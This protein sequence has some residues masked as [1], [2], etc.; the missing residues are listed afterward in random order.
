MKTAILLSLV[1]SSLL[2]S[3]ASAVDP[4]KECVSPPY[5]GYC[6]AYAERYYYDA[7]TNTCKNF[8]YGG[9]DGN[10][11]NYKTL[12]ECERACKKIDKD[13]VSPP[14][15]G[16]CEAI[17]RRYN[18]NAKTNTCNDFIYGGCGGNG[19]NYKT[20]AECKQAY[21]ECVSPPYTGD[22]EALAIRYNY[23]AETNTCNEFNYGGCGGNGN[24]Y[25]TLEECERTC[26]KIDKD[27]VSPPVKGNCEAIKT[28]YN[29]NAAT[30]TCNKFI[31]GGCG[32]NGNNYKTLAECKQAYKECVSPP[33]TGNCE[34]LAIN[35]NYDAET[36][37][38]NK[39]NYGGCGGNG[40]N[41]ETLEECERTCKKIDK[42]C[43]SPPV[44]GN[45]E[46]I[47]TRYNYNA[48]TN[49]CN[50]FIYGGCGGNGNNYKTL[51]ECKQAYKECVSPPYTGNCE[52][53]AI[54]YN[55]DA[56]TNTCN[57]FNYGGCGGNGNNYETLEECER[58][59]K[60]IDKDCVSPPVKGN[61][62]A[63]KTRYNYNAAT[64]T[65]NK[66]IYGGCGGNG[67]NYKTLAECK[68]ASADYPMWCFAFFQETYL[69]YVNGSLY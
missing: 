40:N 11:N 19:N 30:N 63:I 7:D 32:G 67:N 13:C 58:T 44:K 23:D 22:C 65:C 29:Y 66:F 10:G 34:A 51:A 38:C 25:E 55:Y 39:F 1:V 15:K 41:Y 43:V 52:A 50:K 56:E 2:L 8:I 18:Y 20:L 69:S 37:T 6:E 3:I 4:D 54:N 47:K 68:Q 61:C 57:K 49:T 17:M 21:K 9:C 53:L 48:A 59:C 62:E 14:V 31:Y 24:N 36:N 46:A 16:N 35:Y 33:Y 64:N 5:R 60:K 26:K 42:D 45:C 12:E 28:R 27:C